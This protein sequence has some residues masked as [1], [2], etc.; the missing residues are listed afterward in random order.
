MS[1]YVSKSAHFTLSDLLTFSPFN[2]NH[3]ERKY[4]IKEVKVGT[5]F[6]SQSCMQ[7]INEHNDLTRVCLW[8]IALLIS[9]LFEVGKK[10]KSFKTD[11]HH[12]IIDLNYFT[13]FNVKVIFI[14]RVDFHVEIRWFSMNLLKRFCLQNFTFAPAEYNQWAWVISIARSTVDIMKFVMT[15]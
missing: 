4:E 9:D 1:L 6:S 13:V 2:I 11:Y 5:Y 3:S 15:G 8:N 12:H 7:M 10:Q 14:H